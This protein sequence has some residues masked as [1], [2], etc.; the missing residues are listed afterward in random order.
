LFLA[1]AKK[2]SLPRR[3]DSGEHRFLFLSKPRSGI[4]ADLKTTR[5]LLNRRFLS[6]LKFSRGPRVMRFPFAP[7]GGAGDHVEI[8]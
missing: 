5:V 4:F 2:K 6:N 8:F 7:P 1:T 3:I